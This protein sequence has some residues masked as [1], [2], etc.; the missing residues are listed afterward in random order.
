MP[1][2]APSEPPQGEPSEQSGPQ[3]S[4]R[5]QKYVGGTKG[6]RKPSK[7]L[8]AMRWVFDNPMVEGEKLTWQQ[9]QCRD[10]QM[11]DKVEF[12]KMLRDLEKAHAG[13]KKPAPSSAS[14]SAAPTASAA[15]VDPREESVLTLIA[16]LRAKMKETSP[17][18]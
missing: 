12:L 8:K 15:S 9:Q 2:D 14:A 16:E 4:P 3:Q 10:L 6:A 17:S 18:S 1:E 13:L 7:Q 5:R 11:T